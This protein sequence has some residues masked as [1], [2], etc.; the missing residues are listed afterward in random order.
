M[1]APGPLAPPVWLPDWPAP[2]NVHAVMTTRQ[3]GCSVA[4]FETFNLGDHVHDDPVSV[5]RNRDRLAAS[6][7]VQPVFLRQVHGAHCEHIHPDSVH[8]TVADACVTQ[9]ENLACTVMVA[10]CL[11]VLMCD[12]AG[13][14]VGAAH[15]GWRGLAG[16]GDAAPDGILPHFLKRFV[17]LALDGI[18]KSTTTSEVLAWLGPCIG[19]TAFEVGAEVRDAFLA[20][21]PHFANT[22]A[23]F[24]AVWNK[25]GHYRCDLAAL[26]RM[27]LRELG[28]QQ[29]YGNDSSARWCT[30]SGSSVWFSHRRDA[31]RLG[32]T[33]RMAACVWLG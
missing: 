3:G 15:A 17:D 27:Q 22:S 26:A 30:M 28:V 4:P 12:R 16:T 29:L 23:C 33:G 14:T 6:F 10:D 32:S 25:P 19:P 8:G 18:E 5:Q 21:G 11:P 7:S 9:H 20:C 13:R 2:G 1:G 24:D 31:S